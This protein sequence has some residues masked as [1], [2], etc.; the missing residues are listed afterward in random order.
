MEQVRR[1]AMTQATKIR[2]EWQSSARLPL[3]KSLNL[4]A[5]ELLKESVILETGNVRMTVMNYDKLSST[6]NVTEKQNL[7]DLR[8]IICTS[9]I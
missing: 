5:I 4:K 6:L 8:R 2:L 9:R 1:I 3:N 7:D